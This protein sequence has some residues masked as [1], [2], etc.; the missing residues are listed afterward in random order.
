[1]IGQ[2]LLATL[3]KAAAPY[4][5]PPELFYHQAV[6]CAASSVA[7]KDNAEAE[8]T[9]DQF[10][11]TMTW[12]L[13]LAEFGQK[14]KRSRDQVDSGDVKTAEAFYRRLKTTKPAAFAAHRTYCRALLDA[15]RP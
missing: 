15:D 13:I 5:P 6:A 7:A 1:M 14:A 11:E 3:A 9:A 8:P 12:G 10:G 2:L 4:A